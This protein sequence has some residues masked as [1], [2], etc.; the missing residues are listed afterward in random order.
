MYGAGGRFH[1]KFICIGACEQLGGPPLSRAYRPRGEVVPSNFRRFYDR[2]DLPIAIEHA[3][4][5][6]K[7]AWKVSS[8]SVQLQWSHQFL[9]S[10][11]L[12]DFFCGNKEIYEKRFLFLVIF[13]DCV[14]FLWQPQAS[15]SLQ[16][17]RRAVCQRQLDFLQGSYASWKVMQSHRI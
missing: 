5:M 3:T 2:G 16:L 17:E 6:N 14:G 15:D 11:I 7:V 10:E 1:R 13:N 8:L 12:Y 4:F 9:L